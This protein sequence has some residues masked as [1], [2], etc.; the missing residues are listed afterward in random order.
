MS[1]YMVTKRSKNTQEAILKAAE[2]EFVEH[3]FSG[4][5]VDRMA[6]TA[7]VNKRMLYH[8]FGD[9]RG[10]YRAVLAVARDAHRP[11]Q[12]ADN[13]VDWTRH[14]DLG[15][16]EA[17][18]WA[19]EGL[20]AALLD[21]LDEPGTAALSEPVAACKGLPA[22]EQPHPDLDPAM[23]A[24]LFTSLNALPQICGPAVARITG[25]DPQSSEFHQALGDFTEQLRKRVRRPPKVKTKVVLR[26]NSQVSPQPN[27]GD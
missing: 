16:A 2:A 9:K 5:R 1:N 26:P 8:Y 7:G 17:R 14:L 12:A 25:L 19:W 11:E 4:A 10:L 18:L 21:S 20:D 27:A 13:F 24:L 6:A 23:V 22:V 3:G 15:S